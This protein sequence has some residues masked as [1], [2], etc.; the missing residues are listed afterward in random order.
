MEKTAATDAETRA[1]FRRALIEMKNNKS[2]PKGTMSSPEAVVNDERQIRF[3]ITDIDNDGKEE[4][5]IYNVGSC[6]GRHIA[7][8]GR[9]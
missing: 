5:L 3:S 8:R 1:A 7:A 2:Y 6:T 4:L 9:L